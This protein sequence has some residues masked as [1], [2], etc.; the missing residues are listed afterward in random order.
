MAQMF[1]RPLIKLYLKTFFIFKWFK[2][3]VLV[4]A[5]KLLVR[6]PSLLNSGKMFKV[7]WECLVCVCVFAHFNA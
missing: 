5:T 3:K 2:N 7:G 1:P 6:D 4:K